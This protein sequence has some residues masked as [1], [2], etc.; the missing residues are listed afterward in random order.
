M[1][2]SST[3]RPK[4]TTS[5]RRKPH[6][7]S[8][9]SGRP[10]LT[11]KSS[12]TSTTK[13]LSISS[14]HTRTLINTHH[15][16]QKRLATARSQG[17][18]QGIQ[19]IEAQLAAQGGLETYQ[20]ASRTGQSKLR[21]GDS[22]AVLVEWLDA[23]I[24]VRKDALRLLR[25][26]GKTVGEDTGRAP[27]HF[28]PIR[29]LEVGALSTQNALNIP[30]ITSIRRIDLRSSEDG[31]EEIDFM[32]LPIP[33]NPDDGYNVLS[34]S[35]VLNYV[36]DPKARGDMLR[37]TTSFFSP[38]EKSEVFPCLFL[39]LPLPCLENSRYLSTNHVTSILNSLGFIDLHTKTTRKLHYSL[40]RY[41]G[42]RQVDKYIRGGGQTTFKKK[43]L[44]PGGGRNN[45]CI[46]L[47]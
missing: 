35:L 15:L 20:L 47:E 1:A 40:W 30:G 17:D 29:I 13:S 37:R 8:L 18:I 27:G 21:G 4:K 38:H 19:E 22:S 32:D 6:P 14:K 11:T 7:R 31:I 9:K 26:G 10:P 25:R 34:L 16:L 33:N 3:P 44:H 45:F 36:P 24:R 39:V 5:T 12:T 42:K 28:E 43:E 23:E 41:D 46:L 2:G